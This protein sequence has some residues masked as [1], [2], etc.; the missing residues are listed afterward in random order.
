MNKW[1][2]KQQECHVTKMLVMLTE[3]SLT[4]ISF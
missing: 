3:I 4:K 2:N 1:I